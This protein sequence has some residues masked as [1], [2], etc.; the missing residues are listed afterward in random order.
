VTMRE[1]SAPRAPRGLGSAGRAVWRS[2]WKLSRIEPC[3]APSVERLARLEDQAAGL[4]AELA[5]H[6]SVLKRPIVSPLGDVVGEEF[7]PSPTLTPLRRIGAEAAVLCRELGLSPSGR[8]ALGLA[9]LAD[10]E[11][12]DKLDELRAKRERRL[13]AQK[14]AR[15]EAAMSLPQG[16]S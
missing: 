14:A 12:P 13:A 3:D 8:H 10:P 5:E 15:L 2:V 11:G 6:G 16:D 1:G 9:V 4:R 7:Y